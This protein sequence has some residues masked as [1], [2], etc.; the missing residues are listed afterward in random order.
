M[1][2]AISHQ[3][4]EQ[5][6]TIGKS[7]AFRRSVF[8]GLGGFSSVGA[9]LAE[10]YVMGRMFTEAGYRVELAASSVDNVCQRKT[11]GNFIARHLRW[12]LLRSRVMPLIYPVEPLLNPIAL[13]LIGWALGLGAWVFAWALML[14]LVRDTAGWWL[15][16]GTDGLVRTVPLGICKDALCFGVWAIAPFMKHI[17]WRGKRFRVSSGSR[18]YAFGPD[19]ENI[20]GARS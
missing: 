20:A 4:T 15:L 11:V 9:L 14:T 16:R 19:E 5:T 18:L 13:A 3:Y 17:S 10:D 12:G 1:N 6:G 7:L 2:I 8:G